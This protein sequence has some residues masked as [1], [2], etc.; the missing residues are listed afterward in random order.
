[1]N[2][3]PASDASVLNDEIKALLILLLLR[4]GTPSDEIETALRLAGGRSA[5]SEAT[6]RGQE[7]MCPLARA[8]VLAMAPPVAIAQPARQPQPVQPIQSAKQAF[9]NDRLA[10]LHGYAA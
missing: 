6:A 1:M 10:P 8:A 5:A 4:S 2:K 3:N 7:A 9:R